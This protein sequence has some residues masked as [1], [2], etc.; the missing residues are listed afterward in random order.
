[1][2]L[3]EIM[4][5]HQ[6]ADGVARLHL[7]NLADQ[8]P[9]LHAEWDGPFG[10]I[11]APERHLPRLPGGRRHQDT[12]VGDL[13]DAPRRCAEEEGL[14]DA[15]LEHHLFIELPDPRASFLRS[16]EKDSIETAV[17]NRSAA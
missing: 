2:H 1:R 17:W 9:D 11:G 13:F 8:P 14:A 5:F 12:V 16:G 4:C 10:G 7:A 15:G 3:I 6:P